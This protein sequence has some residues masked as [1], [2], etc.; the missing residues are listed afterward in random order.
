[1]AMALILLGGFVFSLVEKDRDLSEG[2]WWAV[3]T[4]TTVGYGDLYPITTEGRAVGVVLMVLGI[5]V[6]GGFT[7]ELATIIIEHRSKRSRGLS[8]V[9]REGHILICGWNETGDD[10]VRNL[11]A[12][13][14][15]LSVV[16]L[17]SL[18]QAPFSDN[19][20]EFVHGSVSEEGLRWAAA[21]E[22]ESA[23][24]LGNQQIE[25][26]AGRD[27]AT[28]ISALTVREFNAGIYVCIQL[29]D[30]GSL[31]HAG[32]SR[33][34]EVVVVGALAGGLL[35]RAV[36]DH[37]SSRAISSLVR[38]EEACEI[39]RLS[40]PADL[41]GKRF[42]D[43]LIAAKRDMNILLVGVEPTGGELILNP[44]G[45]Y[46]LTSEDMIAAIAEERPAV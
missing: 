12:D 26:L 23:V 14:R 32:L 8:K 42:D 16:I 25:D 31:S 39:Y 36:L 13:R 24:I 6:L 37:G 11:L 45:E 9:S 27:A 18:E 19:R 38:N 34:D 4:T 20:V 28:L 43:A 29:F 1:M 7:A 5:G 33:A 3:V 17:A 10:L 35:S 41:S 2:L 46:V 22:A 40:T 44:P 30:S 15:R 21:G